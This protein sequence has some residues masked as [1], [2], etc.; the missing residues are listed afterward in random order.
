MA[1]IN[2]TYK[3]LTGV[4]GSISG[5]DDQDSIDDLIL[6]ISSDEGLNSNYYQISL[7]GDPSNTLSYIYGDSSAPVTIESLGIGNGARIICTTNQTGTKEQRQ[8]Q[9]LDI[10]AL[11]RSQTYNRD[12]LPTKYV[13]DSVFDNP[14]VG[15]LQDGRPWL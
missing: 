9:K 6:S 10:A 11:K 12:L 8:I 3:G 14:N 5:F 2:L 13:G 1:S 4:L 15:G 7:E